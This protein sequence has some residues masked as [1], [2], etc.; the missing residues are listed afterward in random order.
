MGIKPES[1]KSGRG[2]RAGT[3]LAEINVIPLVDI[4]LVLLIIF[5]VTAPMMQTGIG[6]DLPRA[7][8]ESAPAEEG[9][10]LTVTKDMYIYVGDSLVNIN[11]L[12]GRLLEHF[13][14][15]EKKVVYIQGDENLPYGFI[16]NIL[17]IA[18]KAG[19]EV[20]GL[21]TDPPEEKKRR[22]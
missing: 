16:I 8:T 7:E 2:G 20:I 10:T 1:L 15:Q 22:R 21:V 13:Y 4:M 3:S 19:V 5:M 9:L 11:L 18:K 12:E 14:G 17:D 6:V